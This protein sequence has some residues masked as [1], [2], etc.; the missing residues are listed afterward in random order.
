MNISV[1]VTGNILEYLENK[2][3]AGLY[4]SRG[5]VVREAIREMIRREIKEKM[6]IKGLT[7]A[8]FEKIREEVAG[9]LIEKK[10]KGKI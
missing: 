10:Y 2:V 7:P 3:K 8:K 5:E 4:K 1:E 9:E 6:E